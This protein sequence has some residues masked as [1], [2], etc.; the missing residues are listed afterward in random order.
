MKKILAGTVLFLGTNATAQDSSK[1]SNP[2]SFSGYVEAYYSYD[3]NKP[4]DHNRPSFFYSYNR[5]NEFNI[6]LAMVRASYNTERIRSNIAVAS[7]TYVNANYSAEPGVLKNLY[8]GNVGVKLSKKENLWID[9]GVFASHIGFES[10]I[11]KDCWNLTRC[12]VADNTPY[13]ESG[14]KI[15]Y[16]SKN[17]KW[18][19]S[20]LALNGWQRITRVPGN[21]MISWGTQITYT[22]SS[23]VTVNW[24][25]FW[26]TDKPDSAR[27]IRFYNNLYGIFQFNN[28]LG[29]T[30]GLDIG[31]EQVSTGSSNKNTVYSP[32][33]IVR[34][35]PNEKW[36]VAV[37]G[38]YYSDRNGIIVSTG[39]PNGFKTF[40]ASV[41]VDRNITG[42][43][44]WR[45]EFRTLHSKDAIFTK[46]SGVTDNDTFVTTSLALKF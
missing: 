37:R 3:F 43:V 35:T 26:G 23:K 45:T 42:N 6:N 12:I 34:F 10:A 38:E 16:T 44:V 18:L 41:N 13:F 24:S 28:K 27:L 46:E 31:R 33:A 30:V 9:A 40:G 20:A 32:V 17:S 1:Q 21:S 39:T 11:G 14:A 15:T 36:A 8:E 25:G 4:A 7:G 29:L 19:F 2:L 5:H 22:P